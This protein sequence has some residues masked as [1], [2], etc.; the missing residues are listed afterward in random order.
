[1]SSTS[2]RYGR[3]SSVTAA[4]LAGSRSAE[5]PAEEVQRQT[6]VD[7]VLDDEHMAPL[8]RRVDVFEQADAAGPHPRVGRELDDVERVRDR[9]RP[10]EVGEEDDARLERRDQDRVERRVVA[11]DLGSELADPGRDLGARQVDGADLAVLGRSRLRHATRPAAAGSA[12]RGS[13]CRAGRR[14]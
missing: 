1:M 8:E 13:R 3:S 6:G 4:R 14:A 9:E 12:A 10:G 7:D 11:R 5:R 2:R